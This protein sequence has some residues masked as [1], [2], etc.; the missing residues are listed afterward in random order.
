[1]VLSTNLFW[2]RAIATSPLHRSLP[3]VLSAIFRLAL[4]PSLLPVCCTHG[5]VSGSLST[6]AVHT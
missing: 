4:S 3:A 2:S 1:L 6:V 5:L